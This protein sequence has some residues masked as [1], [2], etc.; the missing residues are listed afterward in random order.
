[1]STAANNTVRPKRSATFGLA[2]A[3]KTTKASSKGQVFGLD[4]LFPLSYQSALDLLDE[5][6]GALKKLQGVN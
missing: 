4:R 2:P 1:M 5:V 6:E 3:F